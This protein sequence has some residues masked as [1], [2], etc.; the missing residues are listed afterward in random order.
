MYNAGVAT[1]ITESKPGVKRPTIGQA[2]IQC[3]RDGRCERGHILRVPQMVI[4][5]SPFP[6]G[7]G[8]VVYDELCVRYRT[9]VWIE[10]DGYGLC[11]DFA[12]GEDQRYDRV[13][14]WSREAWLGAAIRRWTHEAERAD[15]YARRRRRWIEEAVAEL[16][17]EGD[18][19]PAPRSKSK[20]KSKRKRN[21]VPRIGV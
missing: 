8:S 16:G 21:L 3:Q 20:S 15:R 11:A 18:R 10:R 7:L 12:D 1:A 19:R 9:I 5:G 2:A 13:L 6:A 17:R 4:N 14:W